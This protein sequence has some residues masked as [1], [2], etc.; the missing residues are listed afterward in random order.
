MFDNPGIRVQWIIFDLDY[1]WEILFEK[2]SE[3]LFAWETNLRSPVLEFNR[4]VT[5]RT[6]EHRLRQATKPVAEP[7]Y[8][9]TYNPV[10]MNSGTKDF[11]M[12]TLLI[13]LNQQ[14]DII[15]KKT[16]SSKRHYHQKHLYHTYCLNEKRYLEFDIFTNVTKNRGRG[17]LHPLEDI[18]GD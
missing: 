17:L 3:S 15:I 2:D 5:S 18:W 7:C 11:E 9:L 6:R 12:W 13:E 8:T 16:L 4:N 10:T 14:K 1:L